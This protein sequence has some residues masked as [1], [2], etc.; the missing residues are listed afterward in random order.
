MTTASE[1][2]KNTR[3]CG[4][5]TSPGSQAAKAMGKVPWASTK[6]G[7]Q[8]HTCAEVAIVVAAWKVTVGRRGL[9]VRERMDPSQTPAP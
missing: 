7:P 1:R 5:P 6:T 2:M 8:H 3:L 9:V 4:Y